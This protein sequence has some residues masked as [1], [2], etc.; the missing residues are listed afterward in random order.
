M[1]ALRQQA[2]GGR[3]HVN[4]LKLCV[5][6]DDVPAL[7]RAQARRL[8]QRKAR[9]EP[10]ELRH[11]T[12][13]VPKR[14]A[15]IVAGGSL[16]WVIKGFVRIR[17]PIVRIDLLDPPLETKRCALILAP[18]LIRTEL[19]ARRPHQGWR[20]L[21]IKDAPADLATSRGGGEDLPPELAAELKALGL[22]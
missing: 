21:E 1:V 13:H 8:E 20:Y 18:R 5:G 3:G 14:A 15:E 11:L 2:N 19:Q 6:I 10:A 7:V 4:L 17:Q 12:R 9:G 22:L 16:Y